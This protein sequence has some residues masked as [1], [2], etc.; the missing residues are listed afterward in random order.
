MA[1]NTGIVQIQGTVGGLTFSKN[2]TVSQAV[3]Q[4]KI[5]SDRT[6]E[7]NTEFGIAAKQGKVIREALNVLKVGD[8]LLT[9]RMLQVVRSGIALDDTNERGKRILS[10]NEAKTV[11]I[12]FQLNNNASFQSVAPIKLDQRTTETETTFNIKNLIDEDVT[13]KDLYSPVG[14]THA[15]AYA[16]AATVDIAPEVLKVKNIVVSKSDRITGNEPIVLAPLVYEAPTTEIIIIA[17]AI[18]FY[19][20]VNSKFYDLQNGA[21]DVAQILDIYSAQVKAYSPIQS[22]PN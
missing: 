12:G 19:Q 14:T 22:N 18:K 8:K 11:L 16:I 10:N 20:Q 5:T 1:R 2:G 21:Y 7:N 17:L 15:A 13:L 4:R 6:K 3:G 9:S